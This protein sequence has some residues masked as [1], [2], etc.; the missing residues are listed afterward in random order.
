[1]TNRN[2]A[3]FYDP[4]TREFEG[5][6][7]LD[8]DPMGDGFLV[9]ANAVMLAPVLV[10]NQIPVLSDDGQTWVQVE[11]YRG[12][13]VY[14]ITDG[15]AHRVNA[16]GAL[17]DGVTTIKPA[18]A[19]GERIAEF[20]VKNQLWLYRPDYTGVTVYSI[21][22]GSARVLTEADAQIPGGYTTEPRPSEAH[23]WDAKK[24]DWVI[25]KTKLAELD[26]QEAQAAFDKAK[27]D[28]AAEINAKAQSYI[29][30]ATGADQLPAFEVQ[31]WSI[32]GAEAKAWHADST[33]PTPTL[34]S[35]AKNRGV[36]LDALRAGAYKKTMMYE[37]LVAAVTGQRQ[38]FND[39][40]RAAKTLAEV[41][42]IAVVYG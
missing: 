39:Q 16:L 12:L 1:M 41:E 38:K 17:P 23:D 20:D 30:H 29:D 22:D 34:E 37:G 35:I 24:G 40:L 31:S 10:D 25:N 15:T 18:P 26:R 4:I 13:D 6:V 5:I 2:K 21:A 27:T 3:Y 33:A 11:D 32:Q 14:Q 9:P 8:R 19:A 7:L 42:S 28:K 36:P